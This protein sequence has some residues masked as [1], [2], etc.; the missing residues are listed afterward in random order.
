L[1]G[2][3]AQADLG[4]HSVVLA[5]TDGKDEVQ[6]SFSINVVVNGI[7]DRVGTLAK[8]YPVPASDFVIMEFA[9][10]LNKA[11]LQILNTAGELVKKVDVSNLSSYQLDIS[12][13]KPS[14]YIYRIIS[15]KGQQTG[16]IVKQ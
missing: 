10:K 14:N 12:D 3:P 15:S 6:Q 2:I 5:V 4:S 1:S 16:S 7:N 11:D 13:L 9:E 8:V